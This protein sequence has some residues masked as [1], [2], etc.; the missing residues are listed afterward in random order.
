MDTQKIYMAGGA[1]NGTDI[2]SLLIP[3]L[4]S[5]GLDANAVLA[6]MGNGGFGGFGGGINGL[7]ALVVVAALFGWGGNGNGLFGGGNNNCRDT[8]L[9]LVMSAIQRNGTDL[10]QLAQTIGC[11]TN[12]INAAINTIATQITTLAG[13]QGLSA[14]QII[15]ALQAGDASI[16]SQ[17]ASCCCELKTAIERQGYENRLATIEQT[18]LLGGKI[19]AQ[20]AKMIEISCAAEKREMQREIH[21]LQE[22]KSALM[23]QLSNEHQTAAVAQMLGSSLAPITQILQGLQREVDGIKCK[24]PQTVS[25]PYPQLSAVNLDVARAVALGTFAGDRAAYDRNCGC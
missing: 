13:Q 22:S 25:V 17:I 24:L 18:N 2:A 4:Q 15:N 7:I 12:Q 20:T 6:L 21:A 5:R 19:D 8:S 16:M 1:G 10:S 3:A 14:Q 23:A 9:D 11:N